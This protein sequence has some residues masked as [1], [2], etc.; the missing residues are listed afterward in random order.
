MDADRI[1]RILRD[2]ALV[3]ALVVRLQRRGLVKRAPRPLGAPPESFVRALTDV[4]G[5][6]F[7]DPYDAGGYL[8]PV[9]Y[10]LLRLSITAKTIH[11][12][13]VLSWGFNNYHRGK[14]ACGLV[15]SD[16]RVEQTW[17]LDDDRFTVCKAC[18]RTKAWTS[19]LEEFE[20][21]VAVKGY[22]RRT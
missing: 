6:R 21:G 20:Q 5:L 2:E 9:D 22:E 16:M 8:P 7:S 11:M 13:Q 3:E 19:L 15:A 4:A 1:D 18:R 17:R 10:R 12:G 14:T